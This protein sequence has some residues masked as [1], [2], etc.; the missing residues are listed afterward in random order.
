MARHSRLYLTYMRSAA[1]FALRRVIILRAKGRC[2]RCHKGG[3]LEVH[4]LTYE[5]LGHERLTDLLA[6][7]P[8]CHKVLD[9]ERTKR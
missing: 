8:S 6:V 4:H 7:C 2:E 9:R 3:R 5:R 1:W